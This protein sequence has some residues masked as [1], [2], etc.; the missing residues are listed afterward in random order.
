MS[1]E[2]DWSIV[3]RPALKSAN[4]TGVS[5]DV[6]LLLLF[7][8]QIGKSI[9]NNTKDQVQNDDNDTKIKQ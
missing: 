6:I 4:K 3:K 7:V 5:Y 1:F 8:S 2:G 9:D